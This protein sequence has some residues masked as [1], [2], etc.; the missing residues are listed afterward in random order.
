[1]EWI[2]TMLKEKL[3]AGPERCG[4]C[5]HVYFLGKNY[6]VCRKDVTDTIHCNNRGLSKRHKNCPLVPYYTHQ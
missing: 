4:N 1:M 2:E 3:A 5:E 6:N